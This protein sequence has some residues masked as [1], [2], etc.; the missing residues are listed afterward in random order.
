MHPHARAEW[1]LF[2]A[3]LTAL[4]FAHLREVHVARFVAAFVIID[5]VGYLPLRIQPRRLTRGLYA[6]TH[7]F[8]TAAIVLGAWALA[9][10]PEWAMLAI[11][12]H[13]AGDRGLF[14]NVPA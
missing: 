5:L 3:A 11:P 12:I 10:R 7:S 2:C 6:V 13:L 14:G 8:L 1:T 9:A 4:T